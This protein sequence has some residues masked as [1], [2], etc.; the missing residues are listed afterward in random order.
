MSSFLLVTLELN[1]RSCARLLSVV[2]TTPAAEQ[3]FDV[4]ILTPQVGYDGLSKF[5][6]LAFVTQFKEH[7]CVM[8]PNCSGLFFVRA[9]HSLSEPVRLEF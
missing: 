7:N 1:S 9:S 8:L 2:I 6:Q 4:W 5:A 3:F